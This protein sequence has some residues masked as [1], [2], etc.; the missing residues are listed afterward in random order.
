MPLPDL[1]DI[2]EARD[3]SVDPTGI[4]E[5]QTN[6]NWSLDLA[7]SSPSVAGNATVQIDNVN[8]THSNG[9]VQISMANVGSNVVLTVTDDP[10][11]TL[12][13]AAQPFGKLF[14]IVSLA[15][16]VFLPGGT[17]VQCECEDSNNNTVE[18][19]ELSLDGAS[20]DE[21]VDYPFKVFTENSG[22]SQAFNPDLI[23]KY[24]VKPV[25]YTHLTLPTILRV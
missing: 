23:S 22:N 10:A 24:K 25:S 7:A 6:F 4:L 19:E 14:M 2:L 3:P 15:P 9:S 18:S 13:P 21:F 17:V 16:S 5:D 12:V 11:P 20:L 8:T 1:P